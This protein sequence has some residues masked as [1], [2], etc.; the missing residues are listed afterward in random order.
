MPSTDLLSQKHSQCFDQRKTRHSVVFIGASG[1]GRYIR[2]TSNDSD[3]GGSHGP[4]WEQC[5][6]EKAHTSGAWVFSHTVCIMIIF[7]AVAIVCDDFFVPSLEVISEKLKLSE[8][9]AGATFM[10]AGSSA[11]EL[12]TSVA[13]VVVQTDVGVGTIV[14]SAVFNLLV[15]I[16]LTGALAGQVL[17]LDWRPM[18]RDAFFYAMSIGCFIGFAW[19]GYFQHY[20]AAILLCLYCVYITLMVFN[21]NLMQ[22]LA[23]WRCWSVP[24]APL[25][26]VAVYSTVA[27]N[28]SCLHK[29]TSRRRRANHPVMPRKST[30]TEDVIRETEEDS[31]AANGAVNGDVKKEAFAEGNG[32]V[33]GALEAKEDGDKHEEEEEEEEEEERTMQ[34]CPCLPCCPA[35][36]TWP[37]DSTTA[38]ENG[39]CWNWTKLFLRWV[40]FIPAFPFVCLFSWTIPDCSKESNKK[41][42]ILSFA[43]AVLWIAILSFGMVTLVGRTGCILGVDTYIMGLV[44][45][46]IGT[47]IPD[48]LSSILVARD[49]FGD[50]AVSNAIGSNVFDINL[51]LGLPFIIRIAIDK[52]VPIQL[53]D[54]AEWA[55]LHDGSMPIV[56]HVKFGFLLLLILFIA[57]GIF[58]LAK[59]RL[60]KWI[61]I[62]FMVIYIMFLSYAFVQEL[63]CVRQ[64]ESYC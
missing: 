37:P 34:L 20:E 59:F 12:F 8:D 55:H 16:A 10:A 47:S 24:A 45:I 48:A 1:A 9:V 21:P 58:F 15:I 39:G 11:P 4:E 31:D 30:A 5:D 54:A 17:H 25:L 44:I 33:D 3:S 7:I 42:F 29:N 52:G 6:F 26:L 41:Y 40:L 2:S 36:R 43:M 46:A 19:D 62:T 56:P 23:S 64:L 60:T 51:G 53:L 22:W 27:R 57:L 49:G 35:V 32:K 50:M 14:G 38:R 61:G 13:G 63:Y 18:L 28:P